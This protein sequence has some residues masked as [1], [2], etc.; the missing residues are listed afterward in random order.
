IW[1]EPFAYSVAKANNALKVV[2]RSRQTTGSTDERRATPQYRNSAAY[3]ELQQAVYPWHLPFDLPAE[4][5]RV[6]LAHLGVSRRDLIEA[7][8]SVQ[9]PFAGTSW[10][11]FRRA[12]ER[13]DFTHPDRRI[14][15]GE[16][17]T[18]PRQPEEFWGSATVAALR[19][20]RTLLDRSGLSFA[21]LDALVS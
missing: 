6:F 11:V 5:A 8:R 9:E 14:I 4:E 19:K 17:L 2:A 21:E 7:M 13:H 20:V 1:D 15:V 16:Q 12:T 10:V 3:A 18:P